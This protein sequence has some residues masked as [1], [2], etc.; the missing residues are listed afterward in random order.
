MALPAY[1]SQIKA[2]IKKHIQMIQHWSLRLAGRQQGF[3][4][5]SE[6]LGRIQPDLRHQYTTFEI[7]TPY[8]ETKVRAQ[9]AFQVSVALQA[10]E[11]LHTLPQVLIAD[12]GD[13]SGTHLDYLRRL[14]SLRPEYGSQEVA[15]LSI[16]PDPVAVGKIRARGLP[17][18]Q[19]RAEDMDR[20]L[21][22]PA[23]LLLCYQTLEHLYNPIE[24]LDLVSR[25]RLCQLLVVTV[26]YLARSRVGLHHIRQGTDTRVWPENTHIFE[27]CPQDWRLVFQHAGWS[28]RTERIYYQYPRN[29]LGLLLGSIWRRFDF[30]GFYGVVLEPDRHWAD[31]YCNH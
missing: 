14:V 7:D 6:Q 15:T 27:L 29:L 2:F 4:G 20:H 16:N 10:L 9:H 31:I 1:K 11:Q 24:F 5:L 8:L 25:K 17:A 30:E 3:S 22:K 19:C 23:D 21:E 12:V 28:I 18:L 26:P 13:S